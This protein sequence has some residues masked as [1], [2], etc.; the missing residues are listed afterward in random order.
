MK[1]FGPRSGF[2]G[3]FRPG[4]ALFRAFACRFGKQQRN[5]LHVFSQPLM[6]RLGIAKLLLDDPKRVLSLGADTGLDLLDLLE[7]LSAHLLHVQQAPLAGHHGHMPAHIGVLRLQ[8]VAKAQDGAFL[9]QA[10]HA[11]I[12]VG[13]LAVRWHVVQRFLSWRDRTGQR[14]AATGGGA[15]WSRA[16]R[17][18]GPCACRD[19]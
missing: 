6:A 10:R 16:Q 12:E 5:L 19:G 15:A 1:S 7:Q 8:E 14:T 11:R 13:E 2:S 4:L 9:G 18:V 3:R 17:V